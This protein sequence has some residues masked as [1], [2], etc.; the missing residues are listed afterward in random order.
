MPSVQGSCA[1]SAL[2]RVTDAGQEYR[3]D[4]ER[5]GQ[6]QRA[7]GQKTAMTAHPLPSTKTTATTVTYK[8]FQPLAAEKTPD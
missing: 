7:K 4:D 3:A 6:P 1:L 5:G 8:P 2:C